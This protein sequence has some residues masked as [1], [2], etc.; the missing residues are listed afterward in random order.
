[1]DA[2]FCAPLLVIGVL[3]RLT[4]VQPAG[5]DGLYG[6]DAY[7]YYDYAGRLYT[8]IAG[9]QPPEPFFWPLGYPAL[10]M[11]ALAVLGESARTAQ[12]VNIALGSLI[13]PL[14]CLL[15]RL[16]GSGALGSLI[17]GLIGSLCGQALQSSIVIMADIPALWWA[18]ASI[19]LL[20]I[21]IRRDRPGWL[22]A[23][24]LMLALAGITRWLYLALA[25]PW[26]L[27]VLITARFRPRWPRLLLAA[28]AALIVLAPQI[29]FSRSNPFPALNHAFVEG[30]SPLNFGRRAFETVEGRLSYAQIN[31]VFYT[32]P[33]TDPYYLSALS[34]PLIALGV[35]SLRRKPAL[36]VLLTGWIG[37]P[38]LFLMGIPAQ[39]IRFPLIMTPAVA[40]LA[41]FGVDALARLR[42]R[43]WRLPVTSLAA[44]L[45]LAGVMHTVATARTM[46]HDFI[47]T[48]QRDKIAAAW[49]EAQLPAGARLYT[50][51]LSLTLAHYTTLDVREIY[52]ET[53]ITLAGDWQPGQADYLLINVW[54]VERQ[55]AGHAP[56]IA[57][58]WL[59]DQRGLTEMGRHGPY[60]LY[61]IEG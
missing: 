17:A 46:I 36:L 29:A 2:A 21:Y 34:L 53:P 30:W 41:G 16:M 51:G 49:A 27:A 52:Y 14:I 15:A 18:T 39:N 7:A 12:A 32:R 9:G 8:A 4:L 25:L 10:L 45:A 54:N 1:V 3:A 61:R 33:L 43:R 20:L 6:Q 40:L 24:A 50:F 23:S 35:G 58:H 28:L 19:A 48:H 11:S 37:L 47:D 38:Y 22:A 56:Q 13:G 5:F 26:L 42:S 44:C 60:T 59:R 55:W 31:A 57:Y